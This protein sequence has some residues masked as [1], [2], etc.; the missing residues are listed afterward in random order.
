MRCHLLGE[1]DLEPVTGAEVFEENVV[2]L[3]LSLLCV[4]KSKEPLSFDST[5]ETFVV[6]KSLTSAK[7]FVF[8]PDGNRAR[9]LLHGKRIL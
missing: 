3:F 8:T 4:L 7:A 5:A 6:R 1:M 2:L 9:D